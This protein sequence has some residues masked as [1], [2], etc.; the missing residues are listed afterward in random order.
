MPGL[1]VRVLEGLI[2]MTNCGLRDKGVL[3]RT[4][5]VG[6][7]VSRAGRVPFGPDIVAWLGLSAPLFPLPSQS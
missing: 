4:E 5:G 2:F 1:G 6:Q 7:T 3:N